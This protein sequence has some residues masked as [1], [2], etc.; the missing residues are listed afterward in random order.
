MRLPIGPSASQAR[1]DSR[2]VRITCTPD[3]LLLVDTVALS[4][5]SLAGRAICR[6][7][8]IQLQTGRREL[9]ASGAVIRRAG[10][11]RSKWQGVTTFEHIDAQLSQE[12]NAP[13]RSI[14]DVEPT[15]LTE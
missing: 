6:L 13:F 3:L 2:R 4:Q 15:R 1:P 5:F 12:R 8:A 7:G 14:L 10:I 9:L 11:Q